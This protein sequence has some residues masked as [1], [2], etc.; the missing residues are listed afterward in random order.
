[1]KKLCKSGTSF[2]N[3]KRLKGLTEALREEVAVKEAVYSNLLP[4]KSKKTCFHPAKDPQ[5]RLLIFQKSKMIS[6]P[7]KKVF[8]KAQDLFPFN[9]RSMNKTN[10]TIILY[11]QGTTQTIVQKEQ[12][13]K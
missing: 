10:H 9:K 5:S 11:T 12:E 4:K 1:M 7:R 13:T 6:H 3:K 8:K 2:Y